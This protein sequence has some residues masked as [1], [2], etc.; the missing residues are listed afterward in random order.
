MTEQMI[1]EAVRAAGAGGADATQQAREA[2]QAT[3]DPAAVASFQSAM[4]PQAVTGVSAV[5]E[6]PFAAQISSTWKAAQVNYQGLLHR[7]KALTEMRQMHG[8]SA[9]ELS[10]L[11]Y[12]VANLSFQQEVVT[13]I[14]KKASD[15]VS[16]LVKNG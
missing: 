3:A 14:A 2:V 13:N 12:N 1:V 4:D 10:E 15:A 7:I 11:Q 5:T 8:P 16:T 6:I 9:A